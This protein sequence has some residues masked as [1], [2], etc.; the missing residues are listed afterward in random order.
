MARPRR[1]NGEGVDD[2]GNP[3]KSLWKVEVGPYV[4]PVGGGAGHGAVWGEGQ[5]D[6]GSGRA[7]KVRVTDLTWGQWSQIRVPIS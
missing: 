1:R 6:S 2:R 7:P 4:A 5:G 3:E